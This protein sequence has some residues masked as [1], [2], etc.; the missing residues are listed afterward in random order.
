MQKRYKLNASF[1]ASRRKFIWEIGVSLDSSENKEKR[2]GHWLR[3]YKQ[4]PRHSISSSS[5]PL[6]AGVY[7]RIKFGMFF[8]SVQAKKNPTHSFGIVLHRSITY[9]YTEYTRR[10]INSCDG[11]NVASYCFFLS[12]R[13]SFSG[14][15][16]NLSQTDGRRERSPSSSAASSPGVRIATVDHSLTPRAYPNSIF[17]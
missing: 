15:P 7:S 16:E 11:A 14:P 5:S 9:V 2:G 8:R 1:V 3:Q 13:Q 17:F 10:N 4:I 6:H 12:L